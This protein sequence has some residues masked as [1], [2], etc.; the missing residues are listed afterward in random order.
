MSDYPE[1]IYW[2][3]LINE[4]GLKLSLVKPIIQRWCVA[5]QRPLAELFE[6]SPLEWETTFGVS[7]QEAERAIATRRKLAQQA[8]ALK[9]WQAAGIEPI[10]FLDA[11][12][13]GR[14][15]HTLPPA[16]QPLILWAQGA[17]NILNQ[18]GV[19]MLGSQTPSDD[20]LEFIQELMT[21]LAAEEVGLVSG[22]G[23]GLD[24]AT[25]E[26]MLAIEN[27][28]AVVVLPMGLSAFAKTT[29]KLTEAASA[30][31]IA[32]LSPFAPDTAFDEKLAE[33]RNVLIDH[34]AL[35]LLIP[36]ADEASQERGSAALD[37]G[38]PV[39][40]SVTDTAGNRAL[41]DRGALL[42]TD[43]GEV[44]ELVQQAVIDAAFFDEPA[45]L[46]EQAPDQMAI[47]AEAG[48]PLVAI[49]TIS[50]QS[51]EDYALRSED[52][53]PIDS[54]EALDILSSGGEIPAILRQRLEQNDD[55]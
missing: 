45:D 39:F 15:A 52:A 28:R 43:A 13:P 23:R 12:Y 6:L 49:P 29:S 16:R 50:L 31:Q 33:A 47:A 20:S 21:A 36:D 14:L 24:R 48:A 53:E 18:P 7:D 4:S 38:M 54:D 44:I 17:L 30:G 35:A 19:T 34:L 25:F 2:L 10:T 27:G 8:A 11:R 41:I 32:L 55:D 1:L 51:D 5:E 3:A 26:L 46:P 42:L 40:V 37:R 9:Q 22:Y